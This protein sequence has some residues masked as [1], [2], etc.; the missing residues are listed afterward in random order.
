[1]KLTESLTRRVHAMWQRKG[2]GSALL[3]PL[4][5][6]TGAV[7]ACRMRRHR[8]HCPDAT[9]LPVVVVG[10]VVVGGTGKTPVVIALARALRDKG[11]RPGIVSRGYGAAAGREPRTGRGELDPALFGDEPALIARETMAP[12][13][14]HPR[15]LLALQ[16]LRKAFPEIDVVLSD[17]G[18]QHLALPRDLE[19]VVQDARGVGNG[20]LLPAGP[21]REPAA[22]LHEVDVIVTHLA[23]GQPAPAPAAGR[24]EHVDM[25]LQPV[26]AVHLSSGQ[27]L[28]WA[29]WLARHAGRPMAAV[30][31]IGQPDRFFAMLRA[32]GA[33]PGAAVAL[34]DHY[35]YRCSPFTGLDQEVI[36]VTPKDAVKCARL[37]DARV[38]SVQAEPV[39]S[40]AGWLDRLEARLR[41]LAGKKTAGG[42]TLDTSA[43]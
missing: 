3:M 17:D 28:E 20:R 23:P 32:C 33:E 13:A 36:L 38:W 30:A 12:V 22:R 8:A 43:T 1:M 34:P 26:A 21:L 37:D 11:W 24:I 4:A 7:V 10:N 2:L 5:W 14:V 18:L 29:Q 31:A 42:I 27:R 35:D 25:R 9:P 6:L 39:F 41:G 16:A 15:R 40:D 19:I